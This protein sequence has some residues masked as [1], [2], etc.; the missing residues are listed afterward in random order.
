MTENIDYTELRRLAEASVGAEYEEE[1]YEAGSFVLSIF[2][3]P[4]T[5]F[6]AAC[7]PQTILALLDE[8]D[9]MKAAIRE[10]MKH[11]DPANFCILAAALESE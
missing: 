8:R 3:G 10:V 11:I 1:W 6:I 9:R 5:K 7:D 2:P 4:D